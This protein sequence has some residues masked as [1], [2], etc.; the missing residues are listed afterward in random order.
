MFACVADPFHRRAH[1]VLKQ[2]GDIV[3]VGATSSL[4]LQDT[5]LVRFVT[6]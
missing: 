2:A 4:D 1:S 3:A 6:C 5:K